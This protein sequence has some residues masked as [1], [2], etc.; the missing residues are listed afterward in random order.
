MT[1]IRPITPARTAVSSAYPDVRRDSAA[2][3]RM[4]DSATPSGLIDRIGMTISGLCLVHCVATTII[5]TL[6]SAAG[7]WLVSP[8]IHEVGLMVAIGFG[9]LALFKGIVEHGYLQPAAFGG[10]GLGMMAGALT[11]PHGDSEL[12][13]TLF[14][15]ALV[16]LG[17]DLNLRASRAL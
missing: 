16:A 5:V 9:A 15:V 17:H 8:L 10:L 13:F 6:L 4:R 11:V 14:G 12:L 7:G 3:Y 2:L 1:Q